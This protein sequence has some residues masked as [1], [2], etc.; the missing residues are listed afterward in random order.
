MLS[1]DGVWNNCI[2]ASAD[3]KSKGGGLARDERGPP[4]H[5]G[6]YEVLRLPIRQEWS[7]VP[8]RSM[9]FDDP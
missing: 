9:A 1:D 3:A 6:G 2:A 5:V 8:E 4:P 7:A